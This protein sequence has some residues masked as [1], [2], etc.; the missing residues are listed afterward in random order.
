MMLAPVLAT[1]ILECDFSR[2]VCAL[3]AGN[4]NMSGLKQKSATWTSTRDRYVFSSTCN[5]GAP[6]T[7]LCAVQPQVGA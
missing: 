6:A 3:R 5:A 7:H 2:F 4:Y 1:I